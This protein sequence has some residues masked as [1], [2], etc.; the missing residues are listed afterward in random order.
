MHGV[1]SGMPKGGGPIPRL[2]IVVP[3]FNEQ[4]CLLEFRRRMTAA[5]AKAVIAD[6]EMIVVNDGSTDGSFAM[7]M[8]G[9]RQDHH[10]HVI[11][12]AR[13][14]SHQLAI[15][16]GIAH[17]RGDRVLVIDADLQDPPELLSAMMREMDRGRTSSMPS[18]TVEKAKAALNC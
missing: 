11:D 6:Y 15:P 2:S 3:C 8:D 12:L 13:N 18:G 14:H 16:A 10:V 7:L 1:M 9:L 4:D 17:A 5:C